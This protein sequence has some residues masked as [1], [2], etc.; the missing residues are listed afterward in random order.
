[1]GSLLDLQTDETINLVSQHIIG[2]H[3][4]SSNLV[5]SNPKASRVHATI[6]W[7]GEFW[8]MQDNS[9]NGTYVNGTRLLRGVTSQ[10][11]AGDKMSFAGPNTAAFKMKDIEPPNS[12][13]ISEVS[14]AAVI[15][16]KGVVVLP[17]EEAPQLT[18]FRSSEGDWLC[19]SESATTTLTCGD[20]ISCDD[21]NWRFIDAKTT[22]ETI[23][24]KDS[25]TIALS[26]I[27]LHLKTTKNKTPVSLELKVN[28]QRL[29]FGEKKVYNLLL[30][31]A[32]QLIAD[33][34]ANKPE[35]ARGWIDKT[36]LA[37]LSGLSEP[38]INVQI[39][40]IRKQLVSTAKVNFILPQMI[41]KRTGEIRLAYHNV[42]IE[43]GH[44]QTSA[45]PQSNQIAM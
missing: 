41:E 30:L 32:R 16:L 4:T 23:C 45:H 39:Y 13:L 29:P 34:A 3:Q 14:G 22:T 6:A 12:M 31:L 38:L 11:K 24:D 8:S 10:L 1:M 33:K 35:A 17:D 15:V 19:E 26:E 2:R 5:L 40:Q 43:S 36:Q 9:T 44:E 7:N 37:N 21:N 20:I 18:L 28:G 25:Q 42:H 27:E